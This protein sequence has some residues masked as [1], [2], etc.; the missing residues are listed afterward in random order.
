MAARRRLDAELVRRGLAPSREV[1]K[2]LIEAGRVLVGGAPTTKA[3][4]QVD[5]A[6]DVRVSGDPP[7]YVSRAGEKLAA[8]LERF[9]V[10]PAG[11]HCVDIGS[12]TGGFTDCLLQN[13]AAS[14]VAVDVGTHQLHE[15]LRSDP[16]V[17]VR[18]QTDI[19]SVTS[20]Q[21][22]NEPTLA[23]GDVSFISLKLV[24]PVVA[25]LAVV[26]ALLLIKPQFEAGRQEVSRGNG[27][28]T[29]PAIWLRVLNEVTAHS[30]HVGLRCAG[31]MVSPITGRAGNVEFVGHF[32]S[33]TGHDEV[34]S[35]LEA[36]V[37]EAEKGNETS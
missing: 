12:S 35:M 3:A 8:A 9:A 16:R 21:F 4:R 20:T 22:A 30:A 18:E 13:G 28:I 7:R 32:V 25:E 15:R 31:L 17:Q 5:P 27:V 11:R 6:E 14:V 24:V 34:V 19:R 26:D 23:V 10:D 33:D 1:A 36:A 37:S 29:D 2:R